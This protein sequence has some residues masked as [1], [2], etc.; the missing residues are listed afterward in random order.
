MAKQRLQT[1]TNVDFLLWGLLSPYG[2]HRICWEMNERLDF[3]LARQED[4]QLESTNTND[5][6]YFNFYLYVDEIN[7]FR[8]ELIKNKNGGEQY[9]KELK[10]FD[11]LLMVKG[12]LDFFEIDPFTEILKRFNSL[13]SALSI[14]IN[15]IKNIS[16][17]IIE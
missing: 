13:Q 16:Q 4:I 8:V 5:V 3:N 10:N 15:K 9:L 6:L 14:D 7:F 1:S 11:Y 17:L 12:E 2:G